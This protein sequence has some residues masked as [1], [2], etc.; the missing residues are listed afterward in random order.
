MLREIVLAKFDLGPIPP[1]ILAVRVTCSEEQGIML[2]MDFS[3]YAG[4]PD[5]VLLVKLSN[6]VQLPVSLEDMRIFGSIRLQFNP[7]I[8]AWPLFSKMDV[9]FLEPPFIDYRLK[10]RT[11]IVKSRAKGEEQAATR[12]LL[13]MDVSSIPGLASWLEQI[14]NDSIKD[15]MVMPTMLEAVDWRE[16]YELFADLEMIDAEENKRDEEL[17]RARGHYT[18]RFGE[19]AIGLETNDLR[20]CRLLPGG[21]AEKQ[22][23]LL[24]SRVVK[25]ADRIADFFFDSD[26]EQAVHAAMRP[27]VIRFEPAPNLSAEYE[28]F[29]KVRGKGAGDESTSRWRRLG[30]QLT[31]AEAREVDTDGDVLADMIDEMALQ[32]GLQLDVDGNQHSSSTKRNGNLAKPLRG[33]R[34]R[35]S[36]NKEARG[37]GGESGASEDSSATF[38]FKYTEDGSYRISARPK[39]TAGGLRM[40]SCQK[41]WDAA[42][43]WAAGTQGSQGSSPVLAKKQESTS[44]AEPGSRFIVEKVMVDPMVQYAEEAKELAA[45]YARTAMAGSGGVAAD[46]SVVAAEAEDRQLEA[47][48]IGPYTIRLRDDDRRNVRLWYC[49]DHDALMGTSRPNGPTDHHYGRSVGGVGAVDRETVRVAEYWLRK[50]KSKSTTS[51]VSTPTS[52]TA[53]EERFFQGG[54]DTSASD[55]IG[56]SIDSGVDLEVQLEEMSLICRQAH[57]LFQDNLISQEEYDEIL[58]QDQRFQEMRKRGRATSATSAPSTSAPSSP[59]PLASPAGPA[60]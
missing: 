41:E 29:V 33:G 51:A 57:N 17:K 37:V 45:E 16:Y 56:R 55:S 38:I 52:T 15:S 9:A 30:L 48:L 23:V 14:I 10:L 35:S 18:R 6:S 25:I 42:A 19:G 60:K 40:L 26:F 12:N 11:D 50:V 54:E 32:V 5:I 7:L 1:K 34:M 44:M 36:A 8:P 20:V 27:M 22:G 43:E 39:F 46:P 24:G 2:D 49:A 3:F 31:S 53:V 58:I 4:E 21:Q 28:V 47:E 13:A 59:L